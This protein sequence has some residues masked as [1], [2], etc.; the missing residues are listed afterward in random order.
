MGIIDALKKSL[1]DNLNCDITTTINECQSGEALFQWFHHQRKK[2]D[3]L[4]PNST[5]KFIDEY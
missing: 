4:S 3:C 5:E 1:A 2:M